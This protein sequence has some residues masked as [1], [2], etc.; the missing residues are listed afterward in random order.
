MNP[1]R[2]TGTTAHT[3]GFLSHFA[4]IE[5]SLR[6]TLNNTS[7]PLTVESVEVTYEA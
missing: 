4:V 7:R 1:N 2:S 3:L 5:A 6:G